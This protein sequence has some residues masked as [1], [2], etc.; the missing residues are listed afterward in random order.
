MHFVYST[1]GFGVGA[2]NAEY[3]MAHYSRY[4]TF[5][6]LD[7]HNWWLELLIN[8]GVFIF[9]GYILF[10][11]SI[12]RQLWRAHKEIDG[13]QLMIC[14][15]LLMSLVGF[16]VATLSSSSVMALT[17]QWILLAFAL[18]F[19]VNYR[20]RSVSHSCTNSPV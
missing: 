11:A 16:L 12:L 1:A 15:A 7:P 20:D 14:E 5:G 3:W 18:A 2:G 8:Y 13:P 19:I 6:I 9:A 17:P 10:F 4:Y